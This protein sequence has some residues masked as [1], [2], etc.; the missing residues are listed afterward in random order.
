M[1]IT[2]LS[3]IPSLAGGI[4]VIATYARKL[5]D[6]GHE[7]VVIATPSWRRTFRSM[8]RD[9]IK[10]RKWPVASAGLSHY[11]VMGVSVRLLDTHRPIVDSDVPDADVVIATWWETAEWAARLSPSKGAKTYMIQGHETWG[12]EEDARRSN[13]TWSL[14]LHKIV[15]AHWLKN[16]AREF[17]DTDVSVVPN[18]VDLQQFYAPPRSRQEPP[19]VGLLYSTMPLKGVDVS[20]AAIEKARRIIPDLQI[21]A[22]GQLPVERSLPLPHGAHFTQSPDQAHIREIY[23]R[24]DV[25]I[26]ASRNEGFGLTVLEAMACRCPVVVTRCGGPEDFVRDGWNGFLVPVEDADALAQKL[27]EVLSAAPSV[28]QQMSANALATATSYTWDDATDAFEAALHR[29]IAKTQTVGT[30]R[31][32]AGI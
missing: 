31:S 6:R 12:T 1:R 22:F 9:L 8:V 10:Q 29:S 17:G 32:A 24:C 30:V 15:V 3:P 2:F 21:R 27:V 23:S 25:W 7:V 14:P 16:L 4:K 13:A 11:D 5:A 20:L 26:C 18:S 28:W 19:T